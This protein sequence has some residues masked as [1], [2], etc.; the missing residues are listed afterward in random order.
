MRAPVILLLLGFRAADAFV[1]PGLSTPSFATGRFGP[2]NHRDQTSPLSRLCMSTEEASGETKEKKQKKQK[3]TPPPPPPIDISKLDIRVGVIQKAWEHE[4]AD[5]L[6]CEEIDIGEEVPR[7]IASGL[8]EY[9]SVE[10]LQGQRVLVLSNLKTR[11]LVGFPSHGMVMCASDGDGKV[12][13]VVPPADATVGERVAV[14]G[15]E[16]DPA[17]GNQLQKKKMLETIFPDLKT[18]AAGVACYKGKPFTTSAGPCK[19][20][21]GLADAE[22]S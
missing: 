9:Y 18:D 13:F 1:V 5:K 19:A 21:N 4:E 20:Q 17:T 10:D 15:F 12:E 14:E 7:Q 3:Q 22:V 16:G 2:I 11:K 8:R 6:F